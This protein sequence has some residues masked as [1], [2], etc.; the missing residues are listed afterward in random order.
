MEAITIGFN[1]NNYKK[2]GTPLA[3][4]TSQGQFENIVRSSQGREKDKLFGIYTYCG[5][6]G[7]FSGSNV[8]FVDIDSKVD[9]DWVMDNSRLIFLCCPDLLFMQKSF[10]GKLHAVGVMHQ[11]FTDKD[12]YTYW[13]R[14]YTTK[15]VGI[16]NAISIQ[17][18]G[19]E[20]NYFKIDN[21]VDS[22]NTNW[23]QMLFMSASQ[24]YWNDQPIFPEQEPAD[25]QKCIDYVN[26][27]GLNWFQ[28]K[29]RVERAI[30]KSDVTYSVGEHTSG[31]IG[32]D[33]NF[34]VGGMSGFTLRRAIMDTLVG[35]L[36][37]EKACEF[38]QD[39]F[40]NPKEFIIWAKSAKDYGEVA[41]VK[42]WLMD[43][44]NIQMNLP[45]AEVS[46]V[47]EITWM[48]DVKDEIISLFN[49]YGRIE[50]VS[51]TGS[52]KTTLINDYLAKELNAVV[53]VPYNATNA[54]YN[55]MKVISS[56]SS[57]TYSKDE[58][59]VMIWDQVN[60]YDI[61]DRVVILDESHALFQERTFRQSAVNLMNKLKR[62]GT[63]IISF[64]ATPTGEVDELDLK[65]VE[66]WKRRD[67]KVV[68]TAIMTEKDIPSRQL[69][70]IMYNHKSRKYDLVCVFD[71]RSMKKLYENLCLKGLE[72][73][74]DY[75]RSNTQE[76]DE[77]KNIKKDEMLTKEITLCTGIAYNGL[78]FRNSGKVLV[79][80]E[81]TPGDTLYSEIIQA[82][83]RFRNADVYVR[84]Y[85]N[86][87]ERNHRS[88]QELAEKAND[89][90]AAGLTQGE[91]HYTV[92]LVDPDCVEARTFVEEYRNSFSNWE[93]VK[94]Q[95]QNTGYVYVEEMN[96]E[97]EGEGRLELKIKRMVSGVW[98]QDHINHEESEQRSHPYYVGW[99]KEL[100][101][102]RRDYPFIDE[103]WVNG[104][105]ASSKNELLV[106]SIL[107]NIRDIL[108]VGSMTDEQWNGHYLLLKSV[109]NQADKNDK[110]YKS[111]LNTRI[112]KLHSIRKEYGYI[113][114]NTS[115]WLQN[116]TDDLD[117]LFGEYVE[118]KEHAGSIGGRK[119]SPKKAVVVTFNGESME[120][121]SKGEADAWLRSQGL[122]QKQLAE[123][124]INKKCYKVL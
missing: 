20:L 102:L 122:S 22:H 104:M 14:V 84:L 2:N 25:T 124:K 17:E 24:L 12:D 87:N 15:F 117:R 59:C 101:N 21:A 75:I 120:F 118:K 97:Y 27:L 38:V 10:S 43:A 72:G 88:V 3:N 40:L 32:V 98:K 112:K 82:I 108:F 58:P 26:S 45:Q 93:I 100:A 52:G 111:E 54:L 34:F 110:W 13:A 18:R 39:H 67:K 48:T 107:N 90:F 77:F 123:F 76:T 83:G 11:T 60:R 94:G 78:N 116:I 115:D 51:P 7:E 80:M 109:L 36:G 44:F 105:I 64:S 55:K 99:N 33:R 96:D 119:S 56:S 95:V 79:L 103:E 31:K 53:V 30:R 42:D 8:Y 19:N 86:T 70:D 28:K 85:V 6:K 113:G 73:D 9:V 81:Y 50:V 121:A 74:V 29:R 4:L 61:S 49:Q 46:G 16:V 92:E 5:M 114:S 62:Q 41:S 91:V 37:E 68:L 63:K 47:K 57:E 65:V 69:G 71:N 66:Y 1:P 35:M 106:D 89:M 23:Y